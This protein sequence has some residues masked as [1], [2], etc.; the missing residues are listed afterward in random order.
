MFDVDIEHRRNQVLRHRLPRRCARLRAVVRIGIGDALSPAGDAILMHRHEHELT[1]GDASEAGLER[2]YER[3]PH[4]GQ[5]DR[6]DL[7]PG[8]V[9]RSSN[10]I[11]VM[12][13][14]AKSSHEGHEGDEGHEGM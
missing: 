5:F 12:P 14:L 2:P 4:D 9:S 3:K 11:V 6:I 13:L 1:R 7:H 10:R 8:I